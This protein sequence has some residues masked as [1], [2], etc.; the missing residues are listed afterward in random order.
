MTVSP[1]GRGPRPV[2]D[3]EHEGADYVIGLSVLPS[4]GS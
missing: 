2:R 1:A 4:L 3:R